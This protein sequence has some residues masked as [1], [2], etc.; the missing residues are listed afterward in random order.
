MMGL[1]VSCDSCGK[2]GARSSVHALAPAGWF[3]RHVAAHGATVKEFVV[4]VC[5]EACKM[6]FF[7]TEAARFPTLEESI[8]D[9]FGRAGHRL[10]RAFEEKLGIVTS[11]AR[12]DAWRLRMGTLATKGTFVQ[13]VRMGLD[14]ILTANEGSAA[15]EAELRVRFYEAVMSTWHNVRGNECKVAKLLGRICCNAECGGD[16]GTGCWC[17]HA[18][19]FA[20]EVEPDAM[21]A[22]LASFAEAMETRKTEKVAKKAEKAVKEKEGRDGG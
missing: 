18:L 5:S 4:L 13:C 20:S 10:E 2:E 16:W 22:H 15:A 21:R 19:S 14:S 17:C 1:T 6:R 9:A 11:P 12:E 7:G 8:V 3:H